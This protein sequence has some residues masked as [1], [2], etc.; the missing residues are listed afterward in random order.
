VVMRLM[1]QAAKGDVKLSVTASKMD[2]HIKK[3]EQLCANK[4]KYWIDAIR[5]M[6]DSL[7]QVERYADAIS[8]FEEVLKLKE[9]P[10]AVMGKVKA[11]KGLGKAAEAQRLLSGLLEQHTEY[12]AGYDMLATLY[13][14]AG[15]TEEAQKQL[16][17]AIAIVPATHR[18]KRA[19][20]LALELGDIDKAQQYLSDVVER[21]K[22]SFFK[23]PEDYTLL[24]QVHME[25]G[26]T[27]QA[28]S[29]LDMVGKRFAA[30]PEIN[31]KVQVLK[32]MS[33]QQDGRPEQA[34]ALLEP[35]LANPDDLPESVKMDLIKTCFLTGDE[36]VA[37][38]LLSD[39]M[40]NNHDNTELKKEAVKMLESVG[41]GDQADE[42]VGVAIQ[43]VI[44]LNNRGAS[45]LRE[46]Q[47]EEAA[48]LLEEAAEKLPRNATVALNAAYAL[49]LNLQKNGATGEDLVRADRYIG[50][51]AQL[52][53]PPKGLPKVQALR[54]QVKAGGGA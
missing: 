28:R 46:G 11:L 39:M 26:D 52:P 25:Q 19:G 32:A 22:Y 34:Q 3:L 24:S 47:L 49:L 45:L 15:N 54:Q 29:V 16:D 48:R 4:N 12:L 37:T 13:T 9:I 31:A 33:W 5:L 43:E 53:N 38:K 8:V 27:E 35:L 7:I 36:E 18:Q 20:K 51:V 21:G 44:E 1:D 42:L 40:Q 17:K 41:M 23:E 30:T 2:E 14:E 6:G 10:W 50:R